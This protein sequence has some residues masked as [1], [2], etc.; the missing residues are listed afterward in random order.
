M[1]I[2]LQKFKDSVESDDSFSYF[3]H[4]LS[5][6]IH[7]SVLEGVLSQHP[8]NQKTP[9]V[10]FEKLVMILYTLLKGPV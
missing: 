3:R 8:G 1:V 2:E 6:S 9:V 4:Q 5:F 7:C 10:K